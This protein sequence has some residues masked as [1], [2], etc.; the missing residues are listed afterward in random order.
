MGKFRSQSSEKLTMAFVSKLMA[1]PAIL[2]L[3]LALL[4]AVCVAGCGSEADTSGAK[5]VAPSG[6]SGGSGGSAG[7]TD[8]GSKP[9]SATETE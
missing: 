8:E 5:E 9:G 1:V 7:E 3:T 2:T 4:C 6:D